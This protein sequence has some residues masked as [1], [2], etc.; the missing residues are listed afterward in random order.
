VTL[1]RSW[2]EHTK[3]ATHEN[4]GG[5]VLKT[6]DNIFFGFVPKNSGGGGVLT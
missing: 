6:I 2:R 4:F 5:L 1:S 3:Y